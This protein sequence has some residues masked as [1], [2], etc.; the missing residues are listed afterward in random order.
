MTTTFDHSDQLQGYHMAACITAKTINDGLA[1]LFSRGLIHRELN[2]TVETKTNPLNPNPITYT[3][4]A[5]LAAPTIRMLEGADNSRLVELT[6]NMVSGSLGV[7]DAAKEN[8]IEFKGW[9][10]V[11]N[12]NLDMEALSINDLADHAAVPQEVKDHL[13][14]FDSEM[15]TVSHLFMDFQDADLAEFNRD[16]SACPLPGGIWGTGDLTKPSSLT[17]A[18]MKSSLVQLQLLLQDHFS[19]LSGTKNPYILGY[20][21]NR[22]KDLDK[23]TIPPT[24]NPTGCNFSVTFNASNDGLSTLN[25]LL[26]TRNTPVPAAP[27]AGL[28]ATPWVNDAALSG[29]FI[30]GERTFLD[31]WLL[32]K[33]QGALNRSIHGGATLT[34]TG[35]GW[36]LAATKTMTGIPKIFGNSGDGTA[37]YTIE[38][39]PSN[40]LLTGEACVTMTGKYHAYIEWRWHAGLAY[41]YDA[42]ADQSWSATLC[43][44]VDASG[45]IRS[46]FQEKVSEATHDY[47]KNG[48]AAF[49]NV[50]TVGG[51]RDFIDAMGKHSAN[52]FATLAAEFGAALSA[53]LQARFVLPAGDV[54]KFSNLHFD[55]SGDLISDIDYAQ[56]A[57]AAEE[58][59]SFK[60]TASKDA[61]YEGTYQR[62]DQIF[63]ERPVFARPRE[64]DRPEVY[65]F[66][67]SPGASAAEDQ[68]VLQTPPPGTKAWS[69]YDDAR[70]EH[71]WTAKGWGVTISV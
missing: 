31:G 4:V 66:C 23:D 35:S 34:P 51:L 67:Y 65:V 53:D 52:T 5:E 18:D 21:V 12:V 30:V 14:R 20:S 42:W 25:F 47:S 55:K 71:P 45:T 41:E 48:P 26:M 44:A 17:N 54:F 15:F 32:P 68:W 39:T 69:A 49:L 60:V 1:S 24:L 29:R 33:L 6:I 46:S 50:L 57:A 11:F 59:T 40:A 70:G 16:A 62:T 63:N 22:T 38:I 43:L 56:E 58:I 3:L 28:F 61:N 8:R 9:R 19:G 7:K 36:T 10:Y 13:Q 37:T 2:L 64:G 27:G